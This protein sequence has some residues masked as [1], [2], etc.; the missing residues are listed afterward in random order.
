MSSFLCPPLLEKFEKQ[1]KV[2][3]YIDLNKKL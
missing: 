2:E 1:N 3:E